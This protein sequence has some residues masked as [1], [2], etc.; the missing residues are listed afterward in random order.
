MIESASDEELW[1]VTA[2]LTGTGGDCCLGRRRFR[3]SKHETERDLPRM[4][5]TSSSRGSVLVDVGRCSSESPALDP[6]CFALR[7]V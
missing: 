3:V 5:L 2:I 1:L 4:V 7:V 6:S